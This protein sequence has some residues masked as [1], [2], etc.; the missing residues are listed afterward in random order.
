M[1]LPL[2]H[3]SQVLLLMPLHFPTH[4][5]SVLI[6]PPAHHF[7]IMRNKTAQIFSAFQFAYAMCSEMPRIRTFR[8]K[9]VTFVTINCFSFQEFLG[10]VCQTGNTNIL[11]CLIL[12][13][14]FAD[15]LPARWVSVSNPVYRH[16]N[17]LSTKFIPLNH[18]FIHLTT[19]NKIQQ[20]AQ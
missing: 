15:V 19:I 11:L 9:S 10:F 3:R 13:L 20:D 12:V 16:A 6:L 1:L 5:K 14:H 7:L 8:Y 4:L 2:Q 18:L 17:I